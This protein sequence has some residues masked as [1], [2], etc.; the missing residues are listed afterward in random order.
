MFHRLVYYLFLM[1]ASLPH[2]TADS[3]I[4]RSEAT[5]L[6]AI[7]NIACPI[8]EVEGIISI[9]DNIFIKRALTL[10]GA[11][12]NSSIIQA[13]VNKN[14]LYI[15]DVTDGVFVYDLTVDASSA[16]AAIVVA[17]ASNV[18][19][20][21]VYV[22]GSASIFAIFYA[23]HDIPAGIPTLDNFLSRYQ[24]DKNN[25]FSNSIVD[26]PWSYLISETDKTEN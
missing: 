7:A 12:H 13:N 17:N 8:I 14:A 20:T 23:G 2:M 3:C 6:S 26:S 15:R 16:Q 21:R 10:K 22:L 5:L 11:W 19:I 4:A 18:H 24:M 1:T 25:T 9:N